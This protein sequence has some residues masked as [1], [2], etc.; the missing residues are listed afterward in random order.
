MLRRR[1]AVE[2]AGRQRRRWPVWLHCLRLWLCLQC[3]SLLGRLRHLLLHLLHPQR[4][5]LQQWL[6]LLLHLLLCLLLLHRL[7]RLHVLRRLLLLRLPRLL[8]LLLLELRR[9]LCLLLLHL[10]LLR[11]L[12]LRHPLLLLLPGG[13][14]RGQLIAALRWRRGAG[15]APAAHLL[16]PGLRLALRQGLAGAWQRRRRLGRRVLRACRHTRLPP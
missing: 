13:A 7:H 16:L 3:C 14:G 4:L 15:L 12:H 6:R 10:L 9:L 11:M 5:S 1:K 2:R 8:R